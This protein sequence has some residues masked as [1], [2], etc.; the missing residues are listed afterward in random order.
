MTDKVLRRLTYLSLLKRSN[1]YKD[2]L[3]FD[4]RGVGNNTKSIKLY[5]TW[6]NCKTWN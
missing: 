4:K 3:K 2:F 5:N 1:M 6:S